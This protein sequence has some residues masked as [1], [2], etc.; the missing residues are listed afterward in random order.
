MSDHQNPGIWRAQNVSTRP[1]MP[2]IRN[3]HPRKIVTARLAIGGTIMAA[4]PRITSRMP[5]IK[6][7]FQCWRTAARIS[8]CNPDVS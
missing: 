1:A 2:K 6:K 5:S 7:A 3:I 4:R 8:E